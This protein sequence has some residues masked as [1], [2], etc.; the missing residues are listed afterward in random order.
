VLLGCRDAQRAANA[1]RQLR[2]RGIDAHGLHL[3]VT[4]PSSTRRPS[5]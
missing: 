1:E 3:D 4:D 2:D 5:G